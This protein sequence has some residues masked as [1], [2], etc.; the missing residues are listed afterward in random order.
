MEAFALSWVASTEPNLTDNIEEA[1]FTAIDEP[2]FLRWDAVFQH[3]RLLKRANI[4]L[5]QA[6]KGNSGFSSR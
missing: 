4:G 6:R 3:S 5:R 2:N 1:S